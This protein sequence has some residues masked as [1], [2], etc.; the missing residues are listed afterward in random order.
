MN[1]LCIR[2]AARWRLGVALPFLVLTVVGCGN[3]GNPE[4]ERPIR[5]VL[6]TEECPGCSIELVEV[7]RLGADDDSASIRPDVSVWPCMVARFPNQTWAVS[8]LVGGGQIGVY[9]S[10]GSMLHTIG[11]SGQGPGEYGTDLHIVVE[12]DD[13]VLVADN[14]YQRLTTLLDGEAVGTVRLPRRIQS[15]ALLESGHLLVH[16]RPSGLEG[17][18]EDRFSLVDRDAGE[19]RSFGGVATDLADLDQWVVSGGAH[20]G[21]W[22]A[23]GWKYE[24]HRWAHADSLEYMLVRDGVDW[25]PLNNAPSD[26]MYVSEPPPSWLTHVWE[27]SDGLLWTYSLVP[28]EDWAPGPPERPSPAWNE[29]VLDTMVEV[30]ETA[31]GRVLAQLRFENTLAPVCASDMMY[32]AEEVASGDV[33]VV[34]FHPRLVR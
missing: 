21:F 13:V 5:Q 6:D 8:G 33:R 10:G 22:T 12:S 23:S 17:D 24:L 4:A 3:D 26:E 25:F 7:A 14:S 29:R 9:D 32:T 30:I 11:R 2:Q 19:V 34:V 28:D 31:S 18:S 20:G 16:G 27:S 1:L 15:L